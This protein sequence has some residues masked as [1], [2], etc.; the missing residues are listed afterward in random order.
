[1]AA[2]PRAMSR[3]RPP[4]APVTTADL[5]EF[6]EGDDIAGSFSPIELRLA[7]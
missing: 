4:P 1:L 3:P 2:S 7:A 6:F 5:P